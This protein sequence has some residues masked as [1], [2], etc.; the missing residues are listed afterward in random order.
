[1][2]RNSPDTE[3][4]DRAVAQ[5]GQFPDPVLRMPARPVEAFDGELAALAARMLRIMDDAHGAGLAAPQL[6]ILKR[7]FVY[8]AGADDEPMAL[9][10]PEIVE[11]S[12][13]TTIG[14]EGCLSLQILLRLEH[15]VPIERSARIKVHAVDVDGDPVEIEAEGMAARV[16]QHEIDHLDGVLIVDRAAKEDRREAL[17]LLRRS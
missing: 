11:R 9:V 14:G 6:G 5:I 13:E 10:N 8:Q 12:D 7:M 17:R 16:I 15:D 1:M 2:A 3:T 4:R